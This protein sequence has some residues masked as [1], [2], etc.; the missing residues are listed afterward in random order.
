MTK[1]SRISLF[2]LILLA[3]AW[4]VSKPKTK[5]LERVDVIHI[6]EDNKLSAAN[7]LT[8]GQEH[9]GWFPSLP[10]QGW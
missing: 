1:S 2:L 3:G 5:A 4:I 8:Q 6:E 10:A 9:I 7:N